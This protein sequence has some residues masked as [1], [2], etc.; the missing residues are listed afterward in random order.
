MATH[1][2]AQLNVARPLAP[3]ESPVMAEFMASLEKINALADASPGFVWR[4]QTDAGDATALRPMGEDVIVNMSV[5]R[6]AAALSDFVHKSG[7]VEYLKRRREWFERIVEGYVVLWWV[8]R[9]HRP[10]LEDGIARLALLRANGPSADAFAF[11][12]PHPMPAAATTS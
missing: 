6:D 9:G 12:D 2:L 4:L 7:H 3:L 5:W 11:R 1:E 8:P 10:T